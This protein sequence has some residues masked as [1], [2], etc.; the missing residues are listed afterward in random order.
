M[1]ATRAIIYKDNLRHNI[2]EITKYFPKGVAFSAAV[3]ANGYGCDAV[4]T[5]RVSEEE[6]AKY[7]CVA[8]IK[9]GEEL[10]KAGIKTEILLLSPYTIEEIE[11]LFTYDITPVAYE[12]VI[13]TALNKEG[14]RQNKKINIFLAVDTG[15]GRIGCFQEEVEEIALYIKECKGVNLKGVLTHFSVAD[16]I[17]K[18]DLEYTK[19]QVDKFNLA[20]STLT[21]IGYSN[22][23][24]T[25]SASS[26]YLTRGEASFDMIRAG[27]SI[28]GYYPGAL[29]KE[30]LASKGITL[31][32]RPVMQLETRVASIKL[33]E[34][35]SSIS[36]GRTW[37]AKKSSYI[38]VL[39]IGYAD[40]LLRVYS[41]KLTVAINGRGYK[42]VGRICMDQC[43][44]DLK[45]NPYKVRQF[46]RVIIFGDKTKGALQDASD[47][48]ALSETISYEVI[49]A[50][51]SRVERVII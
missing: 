51:S 14:I 19:E 5:A 38:A 7:L 33:F 26:A 3:K 6:G 41:N 31:N 44:V 10:R 12:K 35:G 29:T 16:S 15:M 28:Y 2:K 1:R 49:T 25:A 27:I 34:K 40:G 4:T 32:L 50:I 21:T 45:D 47:V 13:I 37:E 18:E 48:A 11:G 20:I 8:T 30:Y 36:Y 24:K 9:E 46:D 23:I 17:K 42:I 39:P 43:M 22:L